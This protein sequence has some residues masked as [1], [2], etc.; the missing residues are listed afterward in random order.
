MAQNKQTRIKNAKKNLKKESDKKDNIINFPTDDKKKNEQDFQFTE[1]AERKI[2]KALKEKEAHPA[3]SKDEKTDEE[4][5]FIENKDKS[6][7]EKTGLFSKTDEVELKKTNT[8]LDDDEKVVEIENLDLS[9]DKML[10]EFENSG[11]VDQGNEAVTYSVE[12]LYADKKMKRFKSALEI[13]QAPPIL[14]IESSSGDIASFYLT[15]NLAKKL[16]LMLKDVNKAYLGMKKLEQHTDK[17]PETKTGFS[18]LLAY[19]RLHAKEVIIAMLFASSGLLYS[20]KFVAGSLVAL[21]I[22]LLYIFW[23]AKKHKEEEV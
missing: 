14:K 6:K 4:P 17:K 20:T 9:D 5:K 23:P 18:K 3:P 11:L 10:D 8:I 12:N 13:K 16:S 15:K 7:K 22:G 21:V 19:V 2:D 1:E